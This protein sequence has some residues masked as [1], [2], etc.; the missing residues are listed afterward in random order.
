MLESIDTLIEKGTMS[1]SW[2]EFVKYP[3]LRTI[4]YVA[5][6]ILK[7]TKAKNSMA[8]FATECTST[9]ETESLLI[10]YTWNWR[11]ITVGLFNTPHRM[12]DY[13]TPALSVWKAPRM[14]LNVEDNPAKIIKGFTDNFY[15]NFMMRKPNRIWGSARF[16]DLPLI[17]QLIK[18]LS[19]LRKMFLSYFTDGVLLGD[20]AMDKDFT[21]L[22]TAGYLLKDKMLLFV[23]NDLNK[24]CKNVKVG[25]D[26]NMW[27]DKKINNY[28]LK[29]YD[30]KG[31]CISTKL[32]EGNL[33]R[34]TLNSVKIN[35]LN[36][37]EISSINY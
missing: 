29:I 13:A 36:I 31:K 15:I 27:F 2:D 34:H 22:H 33:L 26:L 12:P 19:N 1:I 10:H 4:D 3:G 6:Q 18:D 35:E 16:S 23:V 30:I 7:R 17:H 37:I 32:I 28:T 8:T 24:T 5:E 9:F 21:A 11:E 25:I 14:N 20:G